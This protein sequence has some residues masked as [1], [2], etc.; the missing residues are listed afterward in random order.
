MSFT[1][2]L[3]RGVRRQ[4]AR[5][6]LPD[7]IL[8]DVYLRL[9]DDLTGQPANL[10]Q[11]SAAPFD[12][13]TYT[14]AAGDRSNRAYLYLFTFHVKYGADEQTLWIIRGSYYRFPA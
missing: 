4:I 2:R 9:Q 13:M 1:V 10:L 7:P 11:R 8:M 5:W 6:H 12:G 3:R 14:F